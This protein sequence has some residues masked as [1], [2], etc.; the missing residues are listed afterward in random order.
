MLGA[1]GP[2]PVSTTD[3]TVD[4]MTPDEARERWGALADYLLR[5]Q[6]GA[7][8]ADPPNDHETSQALQALAVDAL[9]RALPDGGVTELDPSEALRVAEVAA[10]VSTTAAIS[11]AGAHVAAPT[12]RRR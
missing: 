7:T 11:D 2:G 10:A 8:L 1:G 9:A 6:T 3:G 4:P 12:D 5:A